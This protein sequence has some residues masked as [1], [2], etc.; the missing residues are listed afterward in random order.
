MPPDEIRQLRFDPP[1]GSTQI[2]LIRHGESVPHRPGTR[3]SLVDGHGDP[4]LSELGHW[5]AER[6]GDRL[7]DEAVSAIYVSTLT[8]T[9]QT[10][11]P[12]A[13]HLGL[14]PVVEHDLREVFLGEWEGGLYREKA[15]EDHPAFRQMQRE[16]RWDAIPGAESNESLT[17][18]TVAVLER[19]HQAHP[20]ELV[21][22][23]VH[24]GVIGALLAHAARSRPFAFMGADNGSLHHLVMTP[25]RWIMRRYNDTGHLDSVSAVAAPLS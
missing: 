8:R 3:F 1:A 18:R 20:D 25:E 17:A 9:H 10:A 11:A 21:T 6:V 19:V 22:V 2:L 15:A 14:D 7:K 13:A 16:E 12:L 5:Q 4:P 23:V 24:G